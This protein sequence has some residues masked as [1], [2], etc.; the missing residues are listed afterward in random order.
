VNHALSFVNRILSGR[1]PTLSVIIGIVLWVVSR[2]AAM[3]SLL[4]LAY[5]PVLLAFTI[6]KV[7]ELRKDEIDAGLNAGRAKVTE[8]HDKYLANVLAMIPKA[9]PAPAESSSTTRKID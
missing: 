3:M 1:D 4:S 8:I 2:V 9:A 5:L 6:P 7:Y